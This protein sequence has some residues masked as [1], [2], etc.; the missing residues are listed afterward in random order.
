MNHNFKKQVTSPE[1]KEEASRVA[2]SMQ[3]PG[4][5]KDQTRLIANGIQKGI[6]QYKKQHKTKSRELDKKLKLNQK[7]S[8]SVPEVETKLPIGYR[9]HWLPWAL[10]MLSWLSA[11]FYFFFQ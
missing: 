10:L 5:T 2:K 1:T 3:R 8:R 7:Q 11:G 9:Q 4:Q 6:E